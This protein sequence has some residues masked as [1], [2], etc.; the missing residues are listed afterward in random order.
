MYVTAQDLSLASAVPL[1]YKLPT[2]LSLPITRYE[3]SR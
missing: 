1:F 2:S 3:K